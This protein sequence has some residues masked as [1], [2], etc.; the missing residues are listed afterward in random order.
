MKKP[1]IFLSQSG[2]SL[3]EV[4]VAS[5]ILVFASVGALKFMGGQM[6]SSKSNLIKLEELNFISQLEKSLNNA[7]VCTATLVGPAIGLDDD[8]N[9][10]INQV[11]DGAGNVMFQTGNEYGDGGNKVTL[12]SMKLFD[13]LI[14]PP[15]YG[16]TRVEVV[17]SKLNAKKEIENYTHSINIGLEVDVAGIVTK[18]FDTAN[19]LQEAGSESICQQG[20][21]V[22][23]EAVPSCNMATPCNSLTVA[24]NISPVSTQCFI[25]NFFTQI[26]N[27][28]YLQTGSNGVVNGSIT[29]SAPLSGNDISASRVFSTGIIGT[30][31]LSQLNISG[32]FVKGGQPV[33]T[34]NDA[35][36][37]LSETQKEALIQSIVTNM[38]NTTGVDAFKNHFRQSLSITSCPVNTVARGLSYN[39]TSG[40]FT[41]NCVA[42]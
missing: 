16:L 19:F 7:E 8:V 32:V 2:F 3:I 22:Y 31:P 4:I 40:T 30:A 5:S 23:D 37:A 9:N 10:G 29:T 36:T 26:G 6:N 25:G 12:I 24:S 38:S 1:N 14:T 13:Q 11:I 17:I 15:G 39:S 42:P 21:G 18:C 27:P 20:G 34:A 28:R 41:P 35:F 33:A